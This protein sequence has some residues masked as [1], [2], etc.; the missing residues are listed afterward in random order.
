MK[1]FIK[2]NKGQGMMEI[3]VAIAVITTGI[4]G[5]VTLT[6]SN[7]KGSQSSV[8]QITAANLAREGLEVVRNIRD[9]NWLRQRNWLTGLKND[10]TRGG[11]LKFNPSTKIWT[12]DFGDV[13]QQLYLDSYGIYNHDTLG[14]ITP[15]SRTI[16]ISESLCQEKDGS[17]NIIAISPPTFVCDTD[18]YNPV[19]IKVVSKVFWTEDTRPR[20]Y[21]LEEFL[22]NWHEA[23]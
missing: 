2:N 21:I 3:I 7:L 23:Y 22:Y 12:I 13:N 9:E 18:R 8:M 5:A 17:F 20:S 19:G 15:F 11:I 6:Y 1:F 4:A 10:G 16:E 14:Q